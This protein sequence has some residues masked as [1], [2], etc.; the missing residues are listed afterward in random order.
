L[1]G[2]SRSF[3]ANGPWFKVLGS[4]GLE[5]VQLGNGLLGV[6]LFPVEGVNPP[7]PASRPPLRPNTACE[8]QET[9]NLATVPGNPPTATKVDTSSPVFQ[10]RYEASKAT[11]IAALRQQ[12]KAEGSDIGVSDVDA[13]RGLIDELAQRAGNT[14]QLKLLRDGKLLNQAN[15]RKA[16]VK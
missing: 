3:D 6:P 7:K 12:L 1:A 8:T 11:A 2:E 14:A 15:L 9:P 10:Q 4:G 5:T 13:T 16:G